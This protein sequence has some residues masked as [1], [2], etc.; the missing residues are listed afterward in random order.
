MP[1]PALQ[2]GQ[3]FVLI[4]DSITDC[5]RRD[6]A[7]PFGNGYV[8]LLIETLT[9]R[10]PELD[11]RYINQGIG[12]NRVTDLRARWEEDVLAHRPDWLSVKI[13]IN[14]LHSH[15]GGAPDGV[16]VATFRATYDSI[17][18]DAAGACDPRL[19]L[20][21]P[22]YVARADTADPLQQQ[23]LA[24][25]EEYIAVVHDLAAKY[26]ARLVQTHEAFRHQLQFREPAFFCPEPVHPY[27]NGHMVIANA[28]LEALLEGD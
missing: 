14:D 26:G 2:S 3:T 1:R 17:L 23:V 13:G 22:F 4:G 12:G 9:A 21:D 8:R 5:G 25:I 18:A 28:V 15:L 16:D 11:I 24:L 27:Q 6:V 19:V 7:A 10:W 20:I